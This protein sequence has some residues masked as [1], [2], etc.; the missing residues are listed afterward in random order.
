VLSIFILRKEIL[1]QCSQSKRII[2]DIEIPKMSG[3]QATQVIRSK[4]NALNKLAVPV[5]GLS[6]N[7]TQ[8][9]INKALAY[10][11]TD[12]LSKPFDKQ[13]L[14]QKLNLYLPSITLKVGSTNS[15]KPKHNSL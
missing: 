4:E 15:A 14:L 3:L 11:M 9:Q 10:G 5:L 2:Q 7:T 13:L 8:E 6:R 1:R 12:Y